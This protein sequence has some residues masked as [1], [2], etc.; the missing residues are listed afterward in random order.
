MK[1]QR[2][3]V[4]R[5]LV[6]RIFGKLTVTAKTRRRDD[7]GNVIWKCVCQ[8]GNDAEATSVRLLGGVKKSCG[9]L[10]RE[11]L[12]KI[13]KN[14]DQR[15]QKNCMFKHGKFGSRVH[16]IWDGMIQRCHNP[17]SRDFKNWGARGI[18]VC[19]QWRQF[20]GFYLDMGDGPSGKSLGRIDNDKGYSKKNCRWE[21]WTQQHRNKRNSRIIELNGEQKIFP[22]G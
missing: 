11:H 6:G 4:S 10:K 14:K 1:T 16:K 19:P 21:T 22:H 8:C 5:D 3:G 17:K 7:R 20:T 13:N 12:E 15:G 2:R 9:C 18:S